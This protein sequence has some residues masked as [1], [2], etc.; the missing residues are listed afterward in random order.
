M[1]GRLPFFLC[2]EKMGDESLGQPPLIEG[3][4]ER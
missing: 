1:Y 4:F 3:G 2:M